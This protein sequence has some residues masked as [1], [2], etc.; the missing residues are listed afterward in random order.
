MILA[1]T[2]FRSMPLGR[3]LRIFSKSSISMANPIVYFD[4]DIANADAGRVTF[5]L[6]AD[7]VPKVLRY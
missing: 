4:I 6:Y 5:E 3:G 2:A 1:S 7:V